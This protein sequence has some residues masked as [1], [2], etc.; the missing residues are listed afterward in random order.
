MKR[1][2]TDSVFWAIKYL[3]DQ[4]PRMPL[5]KFSKML[6]EQGVTERVI[7]DSVFYYIFPAKTPEE[8]RAAQA[9]SK[10]NRKSV[11]KENEKTEEQIETH[12]GE[13]NILPQREDLLL[14][15][16]RHTNHLLDAVFSEQK[17]TSS[18]IQQLIELWKR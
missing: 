5:K 15:E 14:D 11:S 13:E 1:V 17:H 12:E 10:K 6:Y 4:Y 16:L 8:Y 3:R 18:L 7:S 9:I 2:I